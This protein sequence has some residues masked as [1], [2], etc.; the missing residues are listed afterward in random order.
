MKSRGLEP[1]RTRRYLLRW[2]GK[3]Q[4]GEFGVGGDL[5]FVDGGVGELRVCEVPQLKKA[6]SEE[7]GAKVFAS[8]S[9]TPGMAK[10]ILNLPKGS[11]RYEDALAEGETSA[12]LTKPKGMQLKE[13]RIISGSYVIPSKGG[14]GSVATIKVTE[15]MWEHKRGRKVH[16][17]ER[18]R[19]EVLHK[20]AVEKHRKETR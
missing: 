20:L 11:T 19:A 13:G 18:R 9:H 1:A 14:Q 5:K 17:G 15:G 2:R 3:F 10:L 7:Q 6:T 16:G 8:T 12:S 4:R